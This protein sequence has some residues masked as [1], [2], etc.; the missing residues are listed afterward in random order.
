[1][2]TVCYEADTREDDTDSSQPTLRAP[3]LGKNPQDCSRE[4]VNCGEEAG[5][6]GDYYNPHIPVVHPERFEM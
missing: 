4:G 5:R 6:V 2:R 1:M 3:C